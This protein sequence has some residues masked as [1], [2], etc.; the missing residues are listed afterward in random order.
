MYPGF[1][2][3]KQKLGRLSNLIVCT[4]LITGSCLASAL[5]PVELNLTDLS[6]EADHVAY[7]DDG[8][9]IV[10]SQ[11]VLVRYKRFR[12]TADRFVYSPNNRQLSLYDDVTIFHRDTT[13]K[14][15]TVFIDFSTLSGTAQSI[16]FQS[17]RLRITGHDLSFN[18]EKITITDVFYSTCQPT[19]FPNYRVKSA[20]LSIYPKSGG[21]FAKHDFLY[22]NTLPVFYFPSFFYQSRNY[23]LIQSSELYGNQNDIVQKDQLP[24][25]KFGSNSLEGSYIKAYFGY[26]MSDHS[27]GSYLLAN[28]S[29]QGPLFGVTHT[30]LSSP[31]DRFVIVAN[32]YAKRGFQGGIRYIRDVSAQTQDPALKTALDSLFDTFVPT[33]FIPVSQLSITAMRNQRMT[34]SWV[35]YMP[36]LKVVIDKLPL[37]D[38]ISLSNLTSYD[39]TIED[40]PDRP[41][42]LKSD[43]F[44]CHTT[45]AKTVRLTPSL[46]AI[47]S[48]SGLYSS[49]AHTSAWGRGFTAL[50]LKWSPSRWSS[51]IKYTKK[52]VNRGRSVFHFDSF[53]AIT[54]DEIGLSLSTKLGSIGYETVY[55]VNVETNEPRSLTHALIYS[56]DC[57]SVSGQ[58]D[59]IQKSITFGIGVL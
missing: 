41:H 34:D 26:V 12:I 59:V 48:I 56:F 5:L 43:R 8:E 1:M 46:N 55:A 19:D 33:R 17:N 54:N 28:T 38:S 4:L 25:P 3:Q 53:N 40:Y 13:L 7:L 24:I 15:E 9:T 30:H 42:R 20:A 50:E 44:Q 11:N 49:Y 45:L 36:Q 58:W 2:A 10:A 27:F 31:T 14:A 18:D 35:D 39:Y 37:T 16:I 57:M 22:I 29:E 47:Y 23:A 52:L 32:S 6:V 21:M 51:S